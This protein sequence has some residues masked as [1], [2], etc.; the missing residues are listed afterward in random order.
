ML[1]RAY[2]TVQPSAGNRL[3]ASSWRPRSAAVTVPAPEQA[4]RRIG[5]ARHADPRLLR[6][7][8]KV[9]KNEAERQRPRARSGV[10]SPR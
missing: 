9:R 4:P 7:G 2:G 10:W 5:A 8:S 3:C 6:L 1:P